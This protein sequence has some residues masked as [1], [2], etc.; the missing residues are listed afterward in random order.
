MII[1]SLSVPFYFSRVQSVYKQLSLQLVK[2]VPKALLD[3][4]NKEITAAYEFGKRVA[5]LIFAWFLLLLVVEI[6]LRLVLGSASGLY[7]LITGAPSKQLEQEEAAEEE[8]PVAMDE[9]AP[10][11]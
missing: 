10:S 6:A 9:D 3:T 8:E 4:S 11:M 5:T 2:E 1:A 7:R